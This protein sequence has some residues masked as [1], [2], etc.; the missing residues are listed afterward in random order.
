MRKSLLSSAIEIWDSA[1][2]NDARLRIPEDRGAQIVQCE[3]G[4]AGEYI[5]EVVKKE[6]VQC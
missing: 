1:Y 4:C 6:S 2:I 5:V 3:A